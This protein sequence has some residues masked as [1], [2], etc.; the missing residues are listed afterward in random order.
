MINAVIGLGFGDEGKGRTVDYLCSKLNNNIVVRFNG[1]HQAG[2]TVNYKNIKHTFSNFG[3]GT[4]RG[5]PTY[6]SEFCT[7]D[8]MGII[9]ELA[10]LDAL[11]II[12]ILYIDPE[13]PVTT[14][15]DKLF[16]QYDTNQKNNGTCGVGFGATIEREEKFYSLKY[17]DLFNPT[18]RDLKINSIK[19]YYRKLS[20]MFY[21]WND[22]IK[23]C[24][25][26]IK[27][28]P[29]TEYSFIQRN[30]ENITF[31]GA[32]GL[33]LDQ[34]Y[35]FFPHVTRSSTCALNIDLLTGWHEDVHFYLVTRA[36]QTRHGNGPMTNEHIKFSVNNLNETNL[37]NEY[38]GQF[39][40]SVLDLDLLK[41]SI[42]NA[43][44]R[45]RHIKTLV[46]TCLD[47]IKNNWKLTV[48]KQLFNFDTEQKFI[49]FIKDELNM[50]NVITFCSDTN[51]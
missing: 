23:L 3:S 50:K 48:N 9:N 29:M 44:N 30:F 14:P 11:G 49:T 7:V 17:K 13:A 36:Y 8:P 24:D 26:V 51:L 10:V 37:T 22:F 31:E 32:Q 6:W 4:L 19:E 18:I 2:H 47:Q 27:L 45:E 46:I 34:K 25:K 5:V 16:N 20:P 28:F 33:L 1:G 40:I 39:R 42:E 12:P 21:C 43:V 35:G 38:Q 15:A 41:Y